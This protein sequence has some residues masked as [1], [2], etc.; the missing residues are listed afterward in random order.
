MGYPIVKQIHEELEIILEQSNKVAE[1]QMHEI[2]TR[3]QDEMKTSIGYE[4]SRLE[5]LQKINPT[6]RNEEIAFFKKQIADS[7]YF[8]NSATLKLQ[9][10]RV[11]INK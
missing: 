8:I 2:C 3:G 1:V 7:E 5:A 4:V 11:V 9:A 6:I 10:L